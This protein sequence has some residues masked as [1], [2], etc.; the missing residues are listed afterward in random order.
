MNNCSTESLQS[1]VYKSKINSSASLSEITVK[2][3]LSLLDNARIIL[4]QIHNRHT[5]E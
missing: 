2:R 4:Y 1:E 3:K 5:L